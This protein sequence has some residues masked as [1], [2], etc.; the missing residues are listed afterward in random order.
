MDNYDNSMKEPVLL[1]TTFPN[2]LVT[3]NLG[4]A[5]GMSS[6]I[7]PF[8][9]AEICE[10]TIALL[11]NPKVEIS[12]LMEY[13]IAPDF[14][15][16]AS[17]IYNKSQMHEIF[18]TG[19]GSV[20]LRAKYRYDKEANCIEILE[21]P[22]STSVELIMKRL[23]D[24][25]KDGKLREVTDFRDEIDL[26]GFKL[27]LDLRRGTDPDLLMAKLYKLTPLQDNFSCN[28]NVLIGSTPR[29]MGVK[30][31]LSEW[32]KFRMICLRRELGFELG[33]KKDKLHLL[34]GLGK[35]LLDIDRAIAIVRS[36]QN[37]ADVIPNLMKGFEIDEIQAEFIAE[38]KL[39]NLNRE[40]IL[41]RIKEIEELQKEI[42]E[43]EKTIASDTL[44][45]KLIAKQLGAIREKYGK[46]RRTELIY[47]REIVQY[48][49]SD[50]V[51]NFN[52]RILLTH[53]GYFKKITL[54]SLRGNDEQK[55]K[56]NDFIIFTEDTDN[57]PQLLFFTDRGQVYKARLRD[58]DCVK[59]SA[60]GDYIPAKLNFDDGER[61]VGMKSISEYTEDGN[62]TFIFANGK[63]VRVGMKQYETK[64]NLAGHCP[65]YQDS[66]GCSFLRRDRRN[67]LCAVDHALGGGLLP[68]VRR[69]AHAAH[70]AVPA[71]GRVRGAHSLRA[72]PDI[73]DGRLRRLLCA[74]KRR[75]SFPHGVLRLCHRRAHGGAPRRFL[76][77]GAARHRVRVRAGRTVLACAIAG[78]R[79]RRELQ[80]GQRSHDLRYA[81]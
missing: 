14:P 16:G 41:N 24:L 53:D 27:T 71:R 17:I 21:I 72:A 37:D 1:P 64:S 69:A 35:I 43:L 63:G 62:F 33:K 73:A 66:S 77:A 59:A 52:C 61:V 7:C 55:L 26:S 48:N 23:T 34:L 51:E 31:L 6:S 22:Y 15:G 11:K 54:Q 2:I 56:E 44:M 28:F 76:H 18:R 60:L 68:L 32:I 42:A 39:R 3:P 79:P 65:V 25:L 58:F 8:N 30:E 36:T 10:G 19:Q 50:H 9:L 46:P 57:L 75:K 81:V 74:A 70:G 12:E 80:A 67:G 13:I 45:K 49:E 4:I 38:I 20:P 47:E 5:V 78:F 40:Y 29:Q